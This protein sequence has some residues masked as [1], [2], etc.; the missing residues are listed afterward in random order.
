MSDFQPT[1]SSLRAGDKSPFVWNAGAWLGSLLGGSAWVLLAGI[2]LLFQDIPSAAVCLG[3]FAA[4]NTYGLHLWRR[5]DKLGAYE[6]FQR[7]ML[8]FTLFY[9]III[10]V[11]NVRGITESPTP[12]GGIPTRVP[13]W[14]IGL[15]LVSMA[16]WYLLERAAKRGS[17]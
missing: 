7:L 12:I 3:S 15:P 9:A 14:P 11:M 4:L 8:A 6:G 1:S 13:Y 10:V 16:F 17:R 2:V 5:R